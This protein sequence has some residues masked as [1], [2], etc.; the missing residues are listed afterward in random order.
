MNI[1]KNSLIKLYSVNYYPSII[2]FSEIKVFYHFNSEIE[3]FKQ[4]T[5]V[6]KLSQDVHAFYMKCNYKKFYKG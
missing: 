3:T 2:D 5:D 1:E 6:K 4:I